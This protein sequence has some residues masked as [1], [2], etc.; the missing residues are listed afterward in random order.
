MINNLKET[1]EIL[2]VHPKS[3]VSNWDTSSYGR[4]LRPTLRVFQP[5]KNEDNEESI[6]RE[7]QA[8][9]GLKKTEY[10]NNGNL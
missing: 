6:G 3:L 10:D 8:I 4:S 2:M 9:A 7:A 1:C 5:R